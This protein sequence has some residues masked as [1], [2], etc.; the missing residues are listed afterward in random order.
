MSIGAPALM[1]LIARPGQEMPIAN[2]PEP[3]CLQGL[4]PEWIVQFIKVLK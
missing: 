2:S 1:I 4:E 3:A